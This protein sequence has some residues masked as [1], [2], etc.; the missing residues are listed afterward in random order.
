M[1]ITISEIDQERSNVQTHMSQLTFQ[2]TCIA[3][4]LSCDDSR[5]V[6]LG[7]SEVCLL[8]LGGLRGLLFL[9]GL[10]ALLSL[11]ADQVARTCLGSSV[12]RRR[13]ATL[14]IAALLFDLLALSFD[15]LG[16]SLLDGSVRIETD[17]D[18]DVLQWVPLQHAMLLILLR[19]ADSLENLVT[20]EKSGEVADCYLRGRQIVIVLLLGRLLVC[21][22]DGVEPL[23]RRLSPDAEPSNMAAGSNLQQV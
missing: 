6:L 19:S 2:R 9:G 7:S 4:I 10:S 23:E 15:S 21:A 18:V 1:S 12:S 5:D 11:F 17:H 20:L 8:L 16:G 3:D 22:V 13:D 14:S